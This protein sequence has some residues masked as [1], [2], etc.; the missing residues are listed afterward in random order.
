MILK[1]SKSLN[2]KKEYTLIKIDKYDRLIDLEHFKDGNQVYESP[3][4]FYFYIDKIIDIDNCEKF[5]IIAKKG[6]IVSLTARDN[7][8]LVFPSKKTFSIAFNLKYHEVLQYKYEEVLYEGKPYEVKYV[9]EKDDKVCDGVIYTLAQLCTYVSSLIK[10]Y[11]YRKTIDFINK[12]DKNDD[13]IKRVINKYYDSKKEIKLNRLYELNVKKIYLDENNKWHSFENINITHSNKYLYDYY[14]IRMFAYMILTK[15]KNDIETDNDALYCF[16]TTFNTLDDVYDFLE[17]NQDIVNN[18][19]IES[20][21]LFNNPNSM[22][23]SYAPYIN[24]VYMFYDYNNVKTYLYRNVDSCYFKEK[25][26]KQTY[27][28]TRFK[29]KIRGIKINYTNE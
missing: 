10:G 18:F 8:Y 7:S 4:H 27:V 5:K 26:L 29:H 2:D 28:S 19:F 11:N 16:G 21:I 13:K 17:E 23:T 6:D 20:E 22:F 9:K 1:F 14:L 24:G 12:D 3:E 25:S 15:S